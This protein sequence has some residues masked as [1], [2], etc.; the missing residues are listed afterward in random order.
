MTAGRGRGVSFVADRIVNPPAVGR[1]G[2]RGGPTPNAEQV[3]ALERGNTTYNEICFSCHGDDGRGTPTPGGGAGSTLAP[4]LVG[5]DRVNAHRDYVIKAILH[6][7]SGPID[8]RSY[9]Q[10]MPAN[11][12]NR[13]E[14]VADVASFIRNG[15]GNC[16][17]IRDD[18]PTSP[19]CARQR[20]TEERRG[21]TTHSRRRFPGR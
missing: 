14:W 11:G 17:R 10:V 21:H 6:G 9:P 19:A 5:S 1:G 3:A 7:L 8:G 13:D 4:S 12:A 18:V 15:F 2:G 20:P 16:R